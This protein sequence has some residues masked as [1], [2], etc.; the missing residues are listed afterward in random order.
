MRSHFRRLCR[1]PTMEIIDWRC[2]GHAEP[3]AAEEWSDVHEVVVAR[4]GAYVRRAVGEDVFV[5]PGTVAFCHPGEAYRVRHPLPGGDVCSAFRLPADVAR[6]LLQATDPAAADRPVP[7]FPVSSTPVDGRTYLLHRLAV[8]A[9]AD[10]ATAPFEVEERAFGFLVAAVASASAG[11]RARR[12][13]SSA[14]R[15]RRHVEQAW[16]AREVL[17][18]RYREHLGLSDLAR[19]VGCSPFHLSRLFTAL[20]GLPIHRAVLRLRLRDALERLLATRD[21]IAAVAYATGFASHS[22]LT[23]AFRREYGY[24]PSA[25]RRLGARD[26]SAVRSRAGLH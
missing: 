14:R 3:F 5:E 6:E 16:C 2:A 15:T 7:R 9:A 21:G 12:G 26:L 1:G 11:A 24:P 22:H 8:C 17:A 13:G 10:P 25:V 18:R 20:V 4:R 23:D 19:D